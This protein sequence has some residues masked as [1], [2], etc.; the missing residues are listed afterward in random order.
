[1]S[2][3]NTMGKKRCY[4][5]WEC[6]SLSC[7]IILILNTTEEKRRG[8]GCSSGNLPSASLNKETNQ[9]SQ[10]NNWL[11]KQCILACMILVYGHRY[12]IEGSQTLF[13]S[14]QHSGTIKTQLECAAVVQAAN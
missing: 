6:E 11:R 4:A 3:Q 8:V 14:K 10:Y 13:H 2:S 1:M 9:Q 7:E 5:E 12:F